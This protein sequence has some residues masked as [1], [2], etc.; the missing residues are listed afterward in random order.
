MWLGGFDR[1]WANKMLVKGRRIAE[2][3]EGNRL[4]EL[5]NTELSNRLAKLKA[6]DK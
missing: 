4:I 2:L 3:N 1:K 6:L 5:R